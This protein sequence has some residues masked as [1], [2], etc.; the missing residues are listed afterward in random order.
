MISFQSTDEILRADLSKLFLNATKNQPNINYKYGDYVK[1]ITQTSENVTVTYANSSKAESFDLVVG[2]DGST[3]KIRSLILDSQ[4]LEG[5]YNFIGQ[6]LA[7]FSI[8]RQASDENVWKWFSAPKGLAIMTRPHRNPETMGAYLGVTMPKRGVRD[9]RVEKAMDEG[10]DAQKRILREY[11]QGVGWEA[12]RVL[13]AMDHAEDFYMSKAAQVKLPKWTNGRSVVIGDA[14]LAT[15][16]V[17][18][19]LAMLS[20]YLLAGELSKIRSS[21]DIPQALE[22]YEQVFRPIYAKMEELPPGFPQIAFPQTKWGIW[23]LHW[24]F[25]FVSTTKVYKLAQKFGGDEKGW[26]LPQYDWAD[27]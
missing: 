26:D 17:G 6:Y 21:E 8:P 19:T 23:L 27:I 18:T 9:E 22:R 15:F 25:W 16:G 12:E 11:L 1:T 13:D 5:S 10:V 24:V 2:A 20:G 3:S 7:F 14:A 4:S